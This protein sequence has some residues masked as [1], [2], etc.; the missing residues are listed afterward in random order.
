M[1]RKEELETKSAF[2]QKKSL[3]C[4]GLLKR[5]TVG[6]RAGHV[7]SVFDDEQEKRRSFCECASSSGTFVGEIR[8]S[9]CRF[10]Y[11][12]SRQHLDNISTTTA[13]ILV[14]GGER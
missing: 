7:L 2:K 3:A 11:S 5:Q 12:A 8:K 6:A 13:S 14:K 10:L 9:Q 1:K 4:F